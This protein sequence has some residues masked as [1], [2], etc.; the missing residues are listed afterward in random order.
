MDTVGL[1]LA[2]YLSWLKQERTK[3]IHML[4][5][6]PSLAHRDA[7][8]TESGFNRGGYSAEGLSNTGWDNNS[9]CQYLAEENYPRRLDIF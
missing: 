1:N 5:K 6:N 8:I 7:L 4:V 3:T 2:I 9:I